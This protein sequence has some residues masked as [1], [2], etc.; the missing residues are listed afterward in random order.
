MRRLTTGDALL[1]TKSAKNLY[2]IDAKHVTEW[3][4]SSKS[5]AVLR[6]MLKEDRARPFTQRMLKKLN[7]AISKINFKL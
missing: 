2:L 6:R 3:N 5:T 1:F 7:V 4:A